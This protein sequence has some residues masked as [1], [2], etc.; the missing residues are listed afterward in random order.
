MMPPIG[1]DLRSK[2]AS[3]GARVLRCSIGDLGTQLGNFVEADG[4]TWRHAS[5]SYT[6]SEI[7][8]ISALLAV[9]ACEEFPIP[10][11]L[12]YT[13]RTQLAK[14]LMGRLNAAAPDPQ[15]YA[16][17]IDILGDVFRWVPRPACLTTT[18]VILTLLFDGQVPPSYVSLLELLGAPQMLALPSGELDA[19][20][21]AK[22]VLVQG[23][24]F[25][26]EIVRAGVLP[27][28]L[29]DLAWSA[30]SR[31]RLQL[32][33]PRPVECAASLSGE[34]CALFIYGMPARLPA[35]SSVQPVLD[36]FAR[37][38]GVLQFSHPAT[39][40]PSQA[41]LGAVR[42]DEEAAGA[43]D[44]QLLDEAR[45]LFEDLVEREELPE[46][47]ARKKAFGKVMR[48]FQPFISYLK[49]V[50]AR[51]ACVTSFP[52][53]IA[54][55]YSRHQLYKGVREDLSPR[56]NVFRDLLAA[57][58]KLLA[59][60]DEQLSRLA[61]LQFVT[62][63]RASVVLGLDRTCWIDNVDGVLLHVRSASN[64]TGRSALFLAASWI[65]LFNITR[66]WL[67]E[68]ANDNPPNWLRD[69][70]NNLIDR[71]CVKFEKRTGLLVP[72]KSARFTRSAHVQLLRSNLRGSDREAISALLGHG[73]RFT[74]SNYWRAWP[75]EVEAAYA[76][77][78]AKT[79][80]VPYGLADA[81]QWGLL[82]EVNN[83]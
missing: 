17:Y 30:G 63:A 77:W 67:P 2:M 39:L 52:H 19:I 83:G 3:E 25:I 6:D 9:E 35:W 38:S 7:T 36:H 27:K 49:R 74:R 40:Y 68:T 8:W 59:G 12:E 29:E 24:S 72:R 11:I 46:D 76:L 80:F 43:Y 54:S 20:E 14:D 55:R 22:Q 58:P 53:G 65:E 79:H 82:R 81:E 44:Q 18:M 4:N 23:S 15:T 13:S 34:A 66:E 47:V 73:V 37:L 5:Q 78:N 28:P 75:E 61:I 51:G 48:G 69:D 50:N 1:S 45:S 26:R 42:I 41:L 10:K 21:A 32:P 64:K 56:P 70:L 31:S 33:S 71:I 57:L 62:A 60:E 16:S